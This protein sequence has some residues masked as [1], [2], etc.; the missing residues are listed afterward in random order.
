MKYKGKKKI[1]PDFFYF[2]LK[3]FLLNFILR[4]FSIELVQFKQNFNFLLIKIQ[5]IIAEH[6]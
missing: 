4:L 3:I 2:G 1:A 6:L 5:E